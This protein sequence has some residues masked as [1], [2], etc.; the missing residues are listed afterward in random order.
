MLKLSHHKP[1][2][3]GYVTH[4]G[5]RYYVPGRWPADQ[6][7]APLEM[8]AAY[9]LL[10]RQL[11]GDPTVVDLREQALLSGD[12]TMSELCCRYLKINEVSTK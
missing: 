8:E 6:K 7:K 3:R 9:R 5:K 10:V 2:S 1:T 4:K 11:L 12:L